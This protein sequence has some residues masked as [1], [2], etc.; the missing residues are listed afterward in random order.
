MK[1]YRSVQEEAAAL[2]RQ[3]TRWE[4]AAE[5]AAFLQKKFGYV[6]VATDDH[7]AIG[8]RFSSLETSRGPVE[9]REAAPVQAIVTGETSFR[10]YYKQA[11]AV[12]FGDTCDDVMKHYYVV[13]LK[14]TRKP[15]TPRSSPLKASR[16]PRPGAQGG[17]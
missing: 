3:F 5:M 14:P 13:K 2:H 9:A 7:C 6:V 11:K 10:D 15:K 1:R 12:G 16:K 4:S 8:E 17:K